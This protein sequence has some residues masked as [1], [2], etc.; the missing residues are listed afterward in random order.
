MFNLGLDY[1]S[2][3]IKLVDRMVKKEEEAMKEEERKSEVIGK[4]FET[5]E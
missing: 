4:F 3:R 5:S 2:T 1:A